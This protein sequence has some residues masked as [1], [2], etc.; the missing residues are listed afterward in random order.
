MKKKREKS[1]YL[2]R[3]ERRYFFF[4]FLIYTGSYLAMCFILWLIGTFITIQPLVKLLL[5]LL[6]F[7][8]A[9]AV[10]RLCAER[11][12]LLEATRTDVNSRTKNDRR[13][14]N[15]KKDRTGV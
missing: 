6:F 15:L 4:L 14:R 12:G 5:Y 8:G 10:V 13:E 9:W 11:K 7:I 3:R 1:K 2:K